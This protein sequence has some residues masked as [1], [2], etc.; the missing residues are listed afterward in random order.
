VRPSN[1]DDAGGDVERKVFVVADGLGGH[2]GGD[3]ASRL[4]VESL[5]SAFDGSPRDGGDLEIGVR[6]AIERADETIRAAAAA[7]LALR[8]MGTT[9]VLL[10][11]TDAEWIVAHVGDSRA[12]L[13]RDHRLCR[14]TTDHNQAA[15]FISRGWLTPYEARRHPSRNVVT[16]TLGGGLR[17]TPDLRRLPRR[18]GDRLLLCS[19]GLTAVL[20]DVEIER[21]LKR[22]GTP[23]ACCR[24][25]V[26]LANERGG[27]DNI[28][29]L[30]VDD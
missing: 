16:R 20:D 3:V 26:D 1:E 15:D 14:L 12:Y 2:P 4:A 21:V 13:L 29:V 7:D 11:G 8:D 25:L 23:Q 22:C 28:S 9:V 19:D 30:V 6:G 24:E 17:S 18:A 5:V 27:P 10:V